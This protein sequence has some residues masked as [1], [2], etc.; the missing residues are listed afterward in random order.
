MAIAVDV[1]SA[2]HAREENI[3]LGV[4]WMFLT[5]LLFVVMTGIVRHLGSDLPAAEGAFIRYAVGLLIMAPALIGLFRRPPSRRIWALYCGRGL[6]HGLGV[7]LWF[8]AMARIP[9][10]EVTALGY[11]SPIFVTILAAIFLGERLKAR[12]IVAIVVGLAGVA[13]I[14]RPGFQEIGAGQ[15]AQ[16]CAAPLFAV[17]FIFAKLLTNSA[18]P[19]EIVVMLSLGATL[20]L[21]PFAFAQ[22]VTPSLHDVL[23]LSLV[24]VIATTGHYTL[25]KAYQCA[26]ITVT[27]PVTFLQ[28]VWATMVGAVF[29]GE[30]VDIFIVIGSAII[31]GSAWY[32]AQREMRM[33]GRAASPVGGTAAV[34]T[35]QTP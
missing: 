26:P 25:T 28:I 22:W 15:W 8:Y 12:R 17:S 11:T 21:A 2:P 13:I 19:G 23:W 7:I 3:A 32:I 24:A 6:V 4:A 30:A 35:G 31:V 9:V 5:G 33:R 20:T 1:R 27:Q 29:F 16:I 14:L 34:E 18:R 10:A